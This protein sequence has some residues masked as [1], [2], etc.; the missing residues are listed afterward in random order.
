MISLLLTI[1]VTQNTPPPN[2]ELLAAMK[3]G[4]QVARVQQKLPVVH[5]VVLV[6]DEATYLDELSRWTP[7]ARWPVLFNQEPRVSQFIRRFSP[8]K[9][10]LRESVGKIEDVRSK[11]IQTV[12]SAWGGNNSVQDALKEMNLPPLGVVITAVNDTA[13]TAAVA[14]AAGRGQLL[15]FMSSEWGAEN[16]ILS[17]S[18][19]SELVRGVRKTLT[20]TGL[21]FDSIGD[22][23][24]AI[25]VCMS[26]P[27]RVNFAAAVENP[28]A[29]SDVI[30]RNEQGTRFAWTGWIFGSKADAAYTAMCSL[31]LERDS[32]WFCNT[33][34][35]T[36]PWGNYGLG[37]IPEVLPK[38]GIKS[39]G[40]DG[41]LASLQRAD[42]GGVTTDVVYFTSKG[43]QDFLDMS[44]ERTSPTW[45]PLLDTPAA[46]YFLHSWSLKNPSSRTTVGGVWLSRGVYAYV[47]SS[48]EPMLQAFV[49]QIELLRRTMSLVP[50]LPASR[51]SANEGIHAKPWRINTIGDPLMLCPPKSAIVRN[52]KPAKKYSLYQNAEIIAKRNL[53]VASENPTDASFAKAID[54]IVLVGKDLLACEVWGAAVAKSSGGPL[55]A[56]ASVGPLFRQEKLEGF[57]WAFSLIKNPT[58]LDKDML[59]QLAG[60][61]SATS[62]QLLID[63]L[64]SPYQ[65]DDL[66]AVV[67]RIVKQRGNLA[68][69]TIIDEV[70]KKSRGRNERELRRMRKNYDN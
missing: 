6:P 11:M 26:L 8:E 21:A 36:P 66:K 48:H 34:G 47:G 44:D 16:K 57:L 63:N 62:L 1:A 54:S 24:D 4:A 61:S 46:L 31:F 50:F 55:S 38:F 32:Y 56:S 2:I 35:N 39:V 22:D 65:V 45:L 41:T 12:A 13:R 30:G 33:Y 25:T 3:L 42:V 49:P 17:E 64:R 18:K 59:W 5:Q 53:K 60:T 51:W 27:A 70:L 52:V 37:T 28:V 9:V 19:T 69:C 29:V 15:S 20:E 58:R 40:I 10:W 23:I 67:D 7:V 68:V 43:N 14:L